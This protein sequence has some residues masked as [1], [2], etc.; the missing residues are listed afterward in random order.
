MLTGAKRAATLHRP[1]PAVS[2]PSAPSGRLQPRHIC[3]RG[4]GHN[5]PIKVSATFSRDAITSVEVLDH[6]E[7]VGVGTPRSSVY[8]RQLGSISR[9][10][11]DTVSG[12]PSPATWF[13]L[14]L[15]L[16]QGRGRR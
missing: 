15:F 11:P 5:G 9:W 1:H 7:T 14:S 6:N 4:A 10:W 3:S 12:A 2:P 16:R 8:L 13:S